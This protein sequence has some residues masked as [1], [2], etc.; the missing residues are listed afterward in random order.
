MKLARI[1]FFIFLSNVLTGQGGY[2]QPAE[3]QQIYLDEIE[4]Q[5]GN[6]FSN[7]L[8]IRPMNESKCLEELLFIKSNKLIIQQLSQVAGETPATTLRPSDQMTQQS[9]N[10]LCD[11]SILQHLI[12]DNVEVLYTDTVLSKQDLYYKKSSNAFLKYFYKDGTHFLS[13]IRKI[14]KSV[15]IRSCILM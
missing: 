1:F 10:Q 6:L 13:T 9:N 8:Q 2:F 12:Q 15:W 14:F 4:I 11:T 3:D 5:N 7:H